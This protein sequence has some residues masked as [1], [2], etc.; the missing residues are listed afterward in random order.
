MRI[1][2]R[3]PQHR[4]KHVM[5]HSRTTYKATKLATRTNTR[6]KRRW[7]QVFAKGKQLFP[8]IWHPPCWSNTIWYYNKRLHFVISKF[9]KRFQQYQTVNIKSYHTL[10]LH[11]VQGKPLYCSV[12]YKS[13]NIVQDSHMLYSVVCLDNLFF[14]RDSTDVP[15]LDVAH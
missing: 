13:L 5:T 14:G 6:K 3:T 2:H 10:Q 7:T 1:S 4:T 8:L 12:D 15:C 11:K 9:R